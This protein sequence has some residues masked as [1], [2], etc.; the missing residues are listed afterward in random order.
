[1]TAKTH[2]S[3]P[4][5]AR[6]AALSAPSLADA[7]VTG[8]TVRRGRGRNGNTVFIDARHGQCYQRG[9]QRLVRRIRSG[10]GI[11]RPDA[12]IRL[13]FNQVARGFMEWP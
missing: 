3:D 7:S 11:R 4:R 1:M 8:G 5:L 13:G 2:G 12:V 10:P 9:H 6:V